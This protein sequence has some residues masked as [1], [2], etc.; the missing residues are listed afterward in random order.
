MDYVRDN[1]AN[2][3]ATITP[4]HL[5][6]NRTAIFKGG[7]NPHLYCL[8][9]AKREVHRLALRAAAIS[10][11]AK[12]FLGTDSAPHTVANK[13]SACGCA[14]VFNAPYAIESYAQTFEE[15]NSLDK[16]EGFASFFGP[17]FYGLEPNKRKIT[18]E[19]TTID[20]PK[21]INIM[22]TEIVPFRAGE[23]LMWTF[24]GLV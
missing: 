11:S 22:D 9:I 14:G 19:R 15:E 5:E 17:R 2:I 6:Y 18:L 3:A 20:V 12:F 1:S 10:G 4:H 23:T 21:T 8:P 16:L 13:Q 24:A 7:I